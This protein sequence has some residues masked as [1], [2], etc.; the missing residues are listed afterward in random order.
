M[1]PSPED[2]VTERLERLERHNSALKNNL[3]LLA[4]V[5]VTILIGAF[6]LY[7]GD[8]GFKPEVG[9]ERGRHGGYESTPPNL[10]FIKTGAL[11]VQGTPLA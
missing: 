7:L 1:H 11:V 3:W 6:V 4:R 10:R 8:A 5:G 9:D 2:A